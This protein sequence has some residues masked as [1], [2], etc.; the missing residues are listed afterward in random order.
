MRSQGHYWSGW[1]AA[2]VG[3]HREIPRHHFSTLRI[4]SSP[5]QVQVLFCQQLLCKSITKHLCTLRC[6]QSKWF[7][8]GL[9]WPNFRVDGA[10]KFTINLCGPQSERRPTMAWVQWYPECI[11][12]AHCRGQRSQLLTNTWSQLQT[13]SK[14]RPDL[15][16]RP[17]LLTPVSLDQSLL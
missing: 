11:S 4:V 12:W 14:A 6:D 10:Q 7:F 15:T 9:C 5:E 16:Y 17:L 2:R 3:R 8:E 1:W 13:P